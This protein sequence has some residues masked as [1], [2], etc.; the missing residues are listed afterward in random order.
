ME[1]GKWALQALAAV[2]SETRHLVHAEPLTTPK[3]ETDV[4]IASLIQKVG[5]TSVGQIEKLIA[6]LLEAKDFLQSE[7]ERV[8]R[9]IERY[10]NLTQMASASVR[11]ISDTVAGWREAGHPLRNQPRSGE[12]EVTPSAAEEV[13]GSLC[14]PD[15]QLPRSQGQIRART[16]GKEPLK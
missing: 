4:E 10:T 16:R 8:Q 5:A 1:P 2:E 11:I 13:T 14:V 7:G 12:F 3:S 9:E 6:E 15:E